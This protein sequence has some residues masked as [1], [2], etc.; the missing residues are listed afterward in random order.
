MRE[1]IK[2]LTNFKRVSTRLILGFSI[3]I[4]LVLGL[5]YT[6]IRMISTVN[7]DTEEMVN[8]ELDLLIISSDLTED[9]LDRMNFL[10]AYASTG[11]EGYRELFLDR[12]EEI[13][14][15]E[16]DA[17]ARNESP[18]LIEAVERRA[19]WE[20]LADEFFTLANDGDE[21]GASE[22]LETRLMP[23]GTGV[24]AQFQ[25]ITN[26]REQSIIAFS[27]DVISSG[28]ITLAVSFVVSILIIIVGVLIAIVTT[29]TISIPIQGLTGR[30]LKFADGDLTEKTVETDRRDE[31]GQLHQATNQ[32]VFNMRELLTEIQ[33][34]SKTVTEHSESLTYTTNDVS[35]GSEQIS[36]TM[37]ELA[38]GSETQANHASNLSTGMGSFVTTVSSAQELGKQVADESEKTRRLSVSGAN[39]MEQ[40]VTQ[41]RSIY[42]IV[43]ESVDK[44][45]Q[46]NDQSE[47]VS[48]IVEVINEIAEQTNLLALNASIEAARAGEH[49][50]GFAV[51]AEEVRKL[52]EQVASSIQEVT[53]I[54]TGIQSNSSSVKVSLEES[55]EQVQQGMGNVEDTNKTFQ[56]IDQTI[57][58]MTGNMQKITNELTNMLSTS[59]NLSASVEE[60]ASV[61]Q[62]SAAGVEE[63]SASAEEVSSSM[64]EILTSTNDL[65]KLASELNKLLGQFKL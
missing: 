16:A 23:V 26:Q 12:R 22:L 64:N 17:L 61:S 13:M 45:G 20:A 65:T 35:E 5:S 43:T 15:F 50:R 48:N 11:N 42:S 60:I 37:E 59:Q 14:A 6:N 41:M 63:T 18:E 8:T 4:I 24:I 30:M 56:Q 7:R 29:R 52:A 40:S 31:I 27:E 57:D 21:A 58:S 25:E 28:Q 47:Q 38:S 39:L 19:D 55:Y 62:E 2:E 53:E 33:N 9:I 54:V 3:I 46:L 49:G 44:V 36:A 1:R 10:R 34:V 51:V 32:M